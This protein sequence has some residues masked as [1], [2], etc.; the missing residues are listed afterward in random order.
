MAT[1]QASSQK[2]IKRITLFKIPN[3]DDIEATIEQYKILR[4]TA[5]KVRNHDI[6]F[7]SCWLRGEW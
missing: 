7:A 4:S 5:E 2:Y 1:D 3:E 6:A